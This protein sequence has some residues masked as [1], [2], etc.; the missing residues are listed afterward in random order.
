[1][2]QDRAFSRRTMSMFFFSF[3]CSVAVFSSL[4]E[5]QF[6]LCAIFGVIRGSSD[7]VTDLACQALLFKNNEE[8]QE[9]IFETFKI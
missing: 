1:M 3:N 9:K 2:K 7:L 6:R 8:T 5:A 4:F